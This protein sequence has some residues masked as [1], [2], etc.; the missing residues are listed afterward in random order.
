MELKAKIES[1][2][3]PLL[4]R[5]ANYLGNEVN[6]V[7]KDPLEVNS[8]I[9]LCFPG[10]YESG[11]HHIGFEVNYYLLNASS[12]IWA[13]R[14]YAPPPEAAAW[15]REHKLPLFSLESRTPAQEFDMIFCYLTDVLV[16]PQVLNMLDLAGIPLRS[17][18]RVHLSPLVVAG[19]ETSKYPEAFAPFIDVFL[20]GDPASRLKQ[21]ANDFP[22][23]K[24]AGLSRTDILRKSAAQTGNYTPGLYQA[25]Y[26][27]FDD[28]LGLKAI[29]P[30]LPGIISTEDPQEPKWQHQ[31]DPLLPTGELSLAAG[32]PLYAGDIRQ[33]LDKVPCRSRWSDL[34][35][36]F[37][38]GALF[39][40]LHRFYRRISRTDFDEMMGFSSNLCQAAWM[41]FKEKAVYD[42][43]S[44]R[45]NATP[46]GLSI[47]H[48]Q[49]DS[50]LADIR[51]TPFLLPVVGSSARLRV[52]CNLNL[53]DEEIVSVVRSAWHN[54]WQHVQLLV[55]LG[56]PGER[57]G[58]LSDFV[59]LVKKCTAIEEKP[60]ESTVSVL[61][62][63]FVPL[64]HTAFQWEAVPSSASLNEKLEILKSGLGELSVQ[65]FAQRPDDA[66]LR[67][68]LIRGDR[69]MSDIIES[70]WQQKK[71]AHPDASDWEAA[72]NESGK[73]GHHYLKPVSVTVA[74]PWDHI[75]CGISRASLKSEKMEAS[76]TRL[77]PQ[78]KNIVSI[79][80]GIQRETFTTKS[81][82]SLAATVQTTSSGGHLPTSSRPMIYGRRGKK[83]AANAPVIKR[84]VRIRY[85]KTGLCRFYGHTDITRIFDRTARIAKIPIVYSQ[86]LR[87]TPKISYAPPIPNGVA[88]IAEY[89]DMEIEMGR[90]VDIQDCL[91]Q[92]LPQGLSVLQYAGLYAKVP[93]LAAIINLST[94][95]I[96]TG[97]LDIPQ[98]WLDEW[99]LQ[100]SVVVNRAFRSEIREI[101]IRPYVT[102]L[103]RSENRMQIS[104]Q[105]IEGRSARV[106]EV[107]ESLLAPR[108]IDYRR[109]LV[110]RTGQYA[111]KDNQ[112]LTPFDA[113]Q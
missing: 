50:A 28:F 108:E 34:S 58:D 96:I 10:S 94:Y 78:L 77:H 19:G 25:E 99:L 89:L 83:K 61:V 37:W 48:P 65:V 1:D 87:P 71:S 93:A 27:S 26:N 39:E 111:I 40:V 105:L 79:G 109:L 63:H 70:A 13:E 15:L 103:S 107:L 8:R 97:D 98:V 54:E 3:L 45:F 17:T 41:L 6:A 102:E 80:E 36:L 38:E 73:P 12:S 84:R 113:I 49:W 64:P 33:H 31:V 22:A 53:R 23:W 100:N 72:F 67:S 11:M 44:I 90:E 60:K 18:E 35:G 69:R 51:K 42:G 5:P 47:G 74:L 2:L 16:Y 82:A 85:A 86:G 7:H 104:I 14:V 9:L 66:V 112:L 55:I 101:D 76:Q 59:E 106:T 62:Q 52:I 56:L 68:A 24:E 88:S 110:Q 95:E 75:D 91:N 32:I 81:A 29:E 4:N 46:A 20:T 57:D 21:L 30:D 92:F 43:S